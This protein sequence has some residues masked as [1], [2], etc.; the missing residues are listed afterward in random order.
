MFEPCEIVGGIERL[1]RDALGRIQV[2]ARDRFAA[3]LRSCEARPVFE[4]LCRKRVI[5]RHRPLPPQ[6]QLYGRSS[7]RIHHAKPAQSVPEDDRGGQQQHGARLMRGGE[8]ERHASRR[9]AMPSATCSATRPSS[10]WS[11][12][13]AR[14]RQSR[15]RPAQPKQHDDNRGRDGEQAVVELHRGEV[16][17]PVAPEG[18]Q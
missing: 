18:L 6:R 2:E 4:G 16:L 17:E 11:A 14:H 10:A 15:A 5:L 3:Q 13:R 8:G 1:D 7:C 12:A 9:V